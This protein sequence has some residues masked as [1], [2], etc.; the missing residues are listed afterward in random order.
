M[1]NMTNLGHMKKNRDPQLGCFFSIDSTN[2]LSLQ[3]YSIDFT[4]CR[5]DHT[6]TP[7]S[8]YGIEMIVVERHLQQ[9]RFLQKI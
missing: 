9:H 6:I 2:Q 8:V 5:R 4:V 1:H 3:L 7:E